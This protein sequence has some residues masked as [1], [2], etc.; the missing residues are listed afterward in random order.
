[1]ATLLFYHIT[2]A[3]DFTC[4][5]IGNPWKGTREVVGS[6]TKTKEVSSCA[7]NANGHGLKRQLDICKCN[8]ENVSFFKK[9]K[10][11]MLYNQKSTQQFSKSNVKDLEIFKSKLKEL[12]FPFKLIELPTNFNCKKCQ[13][14]FAIYKYIEGDNGPNCRLY[15]TTSSYI[16]IDEKWNFPGSI[17]SSLLFE[18]IVSTP[19]ILGANLNQPKLLQDSLHLTDQSSI[20]CNGIIS[21]IAEVQESKEQKLSEQHSGVYSSSKAKEIDKIHILSK[22][23]STQQH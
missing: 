14:H 4:K 6:C 8:L 2:F 21:E 23:I 9:L 7:I 18:S 19:L 1:M 5:V 16:S 13:K 20:N 15:E 11:V 17:N 10:E 3:D 12:C 22:S